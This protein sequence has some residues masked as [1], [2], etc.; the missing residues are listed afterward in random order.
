[1]LKEK[2]NSGVVR[3]GFFP[4]VEYAFHHLL[5]HHHRTNDLEVMEFCATTTLLKLC[6]QDNSWTEQNSED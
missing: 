4:G 6:G 3:E 1:V 5:I 2:I